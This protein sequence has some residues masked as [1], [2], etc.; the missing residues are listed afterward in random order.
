MYLEHLHLEHPPFQ[1]EPDLKVFFPGAGRETVLQALV[2]DMLEGKHL[3]KLTGREGS[4]KT[5]LCR[6]LAGRLPEDCETIWITNPIGAFDDLL[7]SACL[8]LGMDPAIRH[9]TARYPEEFGRLLLHRRE[10]GK[11]V[12]LIIDEAEKLFMTTLERLVSMSDAPREPGLHILLSGRPA[13]DANLEQI[14]ALCNQDNI[15]S[16]YTLEELTEDE[17]SAYLEFRLTAAGVPHEHYQELF[18]DSTAA[19]IFAA[20]QGNPRLTN[21]LAEEALQARCSDSSFMVLLDRVNPTA[22]PSAGKPGKKRRDATWPFARKKFLGIGIAAAALLSCLLLLIMHGEETKTEQA[23]NKATSAAPA[24]SQPPPEA[25]APSPPPSSEQAA[26]LPAPAEQTAERPPEPLPP[27]PAAETRAEAPPV[28]AQSPEGEQ[29][30]AALPP[31]PPPESIEEPLVTVPPAPGIRPAKTSLPEPPEEKA[32]DVNAL[33]QERSRAGALWLQGA[34]RKAFTIQLMNLTSDQARARISELL[35]LEDYY[36][37]R[38]NFYIIRKKNAASGLFVF[39]GI[40]DSMEA[41]RKA[42][43]AMPPFLRKHQPYPLPI[44][45]AVEKTGY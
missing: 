11:R 28:P 45:K 8:E 39:Y 6:M 3:V 32:G 40:Y 38:K 12:I 25:S 34:S 1:E 18:P 23:E 2:R 29:Q 22:N 14:A 4:G 9:D 5:L 13:L 41:A 24:L 19:R 31:E 17:T 36:P 7:H 16:S 15:Q 30:E 43:D 42:R 35:V 33:F 37:L 10:A 26:D 20:A 27:A 44:V 21:I